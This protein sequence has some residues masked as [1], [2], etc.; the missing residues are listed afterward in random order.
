[1]GIEAEETPASARQGRARAY[2]EAGRD[3]I[4]RGGVGLEEAGNSFRKAAELMLSARVEA[5]GLTADDV[6]R[7][8]GA[9]AGR[10]PLS[11]KDPSFSDYEVFARDNSLIT[12]S[13]YSRYED[14]RRVGNASSHAGRRG[15]RW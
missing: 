2:I 9:K 4:G 14:V 1:M 7:W 12:E 8:R 6:W 10:V 15:C 13:E 3:A 5:A 11:A